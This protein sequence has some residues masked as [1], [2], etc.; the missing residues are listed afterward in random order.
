MHHHGSLLSYFLYLNKIYLRI[1][2]PD[3]RFSKNDSI[4]SGLTTLAFLILLKQ[5]YP[6]AHIFE[7]Q[8]DEF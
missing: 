2:L 8:C 5:P 4:T 1:K 6:F 3:F 7:R